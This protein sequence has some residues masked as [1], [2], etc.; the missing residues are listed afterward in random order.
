MDK[1]SNQEDGV[2]AHRGL[3]PSA[4]HSI[5]AERWQKRAYGVGQCVSWKR[6][7]LRPAFF[8]FLLLRLLMAP[9]CHLKGSGKYLSRA[10]ACLC[11]QMLLLCASV[12]TKG[13][14][15][16]QMLLLLPHT[17]DKLQN[18]CGRGMSLEGGLRA[19]PS[20]RKLLNELAGGGLLGRGPRKPA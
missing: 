14:C 19:V 8:F 1:A 3:F 20:T 12:T 5:F 4:S 18:Y 7:L 10:Q 15:Q 13:Q 9:S 2:M 6:G 16:P 17:Q 11:L